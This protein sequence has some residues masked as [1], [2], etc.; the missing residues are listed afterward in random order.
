MSRVTCD[1][2]LSAVGLR[3]ETRIIAAFGD[4]PVSTSLRVNLRY[5][6]H[7]RVVVLVGNVAIEQLLQGLRYVAAE[8]LVLSAASVRVL[9]P[10]RLADGQGNPVISCKRYAAISAPGESA[11]QKMLTY[12]APRMRT[13]IDPPVG[14][15]GA[16]LHLARAGQVLVVGVAKLV[17]LPSGFR[18]VPN[19]VPL[20][21]ITRNQHRIGA[22]KSTTTDLFSFLDVLSTFPDRPP[23]VARGPDIR[24]PRL[25]LILGI[26]WRR[27]LHLIVG[28]VLCEGCRKDKQKWSSKR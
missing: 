19:F 18:D 5:L 17:R 13:I 1:V 10:V 11:S 3:N 20:S 16:A 12:L 27:V 15:R 14:F 21:T 22:I 26:N 9:P 2:K 6:D 25:P 8:F 7:V 23:R 24:G 4:P 28:I